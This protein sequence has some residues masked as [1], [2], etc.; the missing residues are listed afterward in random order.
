MG[1]SDTRNTL[2]I[3]GPLG[4]P[5]HKW[6]KTLKWIFENSCVKMWTEFKWLRI[7]YSGRLL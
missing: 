5:R 7:G 2:K 4:R 6:E 1:I 3:M